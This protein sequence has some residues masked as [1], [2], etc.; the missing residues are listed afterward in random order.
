MSNF[1]EWHRVEY[2][3]TDDEEN[4]P[5]GPIPGFV[6]AVLDAIG[7][8]VIGGSRNR[9]RALGCALL[10]GVAA[11][12]EDRVTK[13]KPRELR[14][15]AVGTLGRAARL[16]GDDI[17]SLIIFCQYATEPPARKSKEEIAKLV[18]KYPDLEDDIRRDAE[19]VASFLDDPQSAD[20]VWRKAFDIGRSE[21]ED[22][23]DN[24]DIF[25]SRRIV[26]AITSAP[27][28]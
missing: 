20:K 17:Q 10:G 14:R 11:F 21:F 4:D 26:S 1:A 5:Y 25:S 6:D 22:W 7:P 15:F 13:V 19:I 27:A 16:P 12:V 2:K 23:W 3:R 18:A 8:D 28:D 24:P 9:L